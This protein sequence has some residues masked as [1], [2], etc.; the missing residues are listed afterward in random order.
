MGIPRP[1]SSFVAPGKNK[2]LHLQT[3]PS[4]AQIMSW[5]REELKFSTVLINYCKMVGLCAWSNDQS[6]KTP[7][8]FKSGDRRG[9]QK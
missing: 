1:G 4:V 5:S 3:L 7:N 6:Q 9:R 8:A 2:V